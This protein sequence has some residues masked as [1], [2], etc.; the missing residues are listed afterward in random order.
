MSW[1]D[2]DPPS[3]ER[4]W[5]YARIHNDDDQLA[6]SSPIWFVR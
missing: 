5:Y 1:M 3:T 6:W 4:L 2:V